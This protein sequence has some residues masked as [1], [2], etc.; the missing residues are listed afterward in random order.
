M[1]N[2]LITG[3]NRGIGFEAA[4]QFALKGYKVIMSSRDAEK[5]IKSQQK[6]IQ[7][8]LDA[9]FLQLDV[10]S[11]ENIKQSV[12]KIEQ[13]YDK[14]DV[15]V[16]NAAIMLNK[17]QNITE[18][19]KEDILMV[20]ETNVFGPMLL[21]REVLPLMEKNGFGRII[22]IS[23]E[24]GSLTG[25]QGG[26]TS[27]RMSKTSLNSVTRIFA[28]EVTHPNIKINTMCPGWVK[29]D[30]GGP[31]AHRTPQKATETILWL[32]ELEINGPTGGFF[33]DG[34]KIPW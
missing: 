17:K 11:E 30:M 22:N 27:Y 8:G 3:S 7:E 4:R 12:S 18:V 15:L 33:R 16:N 24:M 28:K 6:L 29:T 10:S 31:N 14:L 2:V 5:G 23:S 1:K 20:F 13:K 34:E 25:T 21:I 26:Y 19:N 32:A 9:D